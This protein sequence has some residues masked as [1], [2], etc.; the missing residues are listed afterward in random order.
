[1]LVL[2]GR[3]P[4]PVSAQQPTPPVAP[5]PT[6]PVAPQP[7]PPVAR[8]P[9][10]LA[11]SQQGRY[12]PEVQE[13][14][15]LL[16]ENKRSEAIKALEDA[17]RKYP[18]LPSAHVIMYRVFKEFEPNYARLQLDEAIKAN[19]GDPEPYYLLG[20]IAL[21]DRR[22]S[23]AGID[24][25]R[26]EQLLAAYANAQRKETLEHQ[27]K[28][29]LANV[30]EG[31]GDWKQA[32][33]YL[34]DMLKFMPEDVIAQQRL[35][36]ALFWQGRAKDAY[37]AL[38]AAKQIDRE[39]ARKHGTPEVVLTPE[40]ILAQYFDQVEGPA[41]KSGN[42]E[43]FFKAALRAA[44]DDLPT[45]RAVAVWAMDRGDLGLCQGAGGS[46]LANRVRSPL[47]RQVPRQQFG[48]RAPRTGRLVGEGLAGGGKELRGRRTR[49]P[50]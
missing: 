3:G 20:E 1:M 17:S 28:S 44:P 29:G 22:V 14:I 2:L 9:D 5:Q 49:G 24:F 35:A 21:Q 12:P 18:A 39:Y 43:K 27:T 25:E 23:E 7:T 11:A 37:D 26:A 10:S 47:W 42:A 31:R 13:A 16:R 46:R 6:P 40:A 45:R 48:P 34:R 50:Q 33:S 32:E 19:P 15:Q 4:A 38:T 30:A 36:R 8:Q 41:S